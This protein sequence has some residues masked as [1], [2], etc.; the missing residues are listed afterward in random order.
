MRVSS[1]PTGCL[2]EEQLQN[3]LDLL[4]SLKHRPEPV[5]VVLTGA[6]WVH[7]APPCTFG[8]A[9]H[10]VVTSDEPMYTTNTHTAGFAGGR[11]YV[12]PDDMMEDVNNVFATQA[13]SAFTDTEDILI[14]SAASY[15]SP[16]LDNAPCNPNRVTVL[17][18]RKKVAAWPFRP[19]EYL[20]DDI[21]VSHAVPGR[22]S[23]H[24]TPA[25]WSRIEEYAVQQGGWIKEVGPGEAGCC[26]MG[27]SAAAHLALV[28]CTLQESTS[29]SRHF[30]GTR[31]TMWRPR[32]PLPTAS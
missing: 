5:V 32:C 28:L 18:G 21:Q 24:V 23:Q 17:T 10:S 2:A 16:H 31:P 15:T 26:V 13:G 7:Q 30:G 3:S 11:F 29:P 22:E 8:E 20:P 1:E 6:E 27:Q 12:M 9:Y 14:G 25:A 19:D 4:D